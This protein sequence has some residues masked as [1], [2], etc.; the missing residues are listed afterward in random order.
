[1][2]FIFKALHTLLIEEFIVFFSSV[3]FFTYFLLISLEKRNFFYK[4][5]LLFIPILF[6]FISYSALPD[7]ISSLGQDSIFE[8]NADFKE[9]FFYVKTLFIYL[10]DPEIF[11]RNRFWLVLISSLVSSLFIIYLLNLLKKTKHIKIRNYLKH[12]N[13]L[14]L[15]FVLLF[16]VKVTNIIYVNYKSGNELEKIYVKLQNTFDRESKNLTIKENHSRDLDVVIYIG[17]SNSA[18]HWSLYGYPFATTPWLESQKNDKKFILFKNMYSRYTHTTPSL[19]DTLSI[20][21]EEKNNCS[22]QDY[23]NYK[24][25]PVVEILKNTNISSYLFSMQGKLGGHNFANKVVLN[26]NYKFYSADKSRLYLGNRSSSKIKDREF[27]L[28]SYCK[29]K[30]IFNKNFSNLILL[31]SYAGHFGFNGYRY[32]VPND[33]NFNYPTYLN[34]KNFLGN[35]HKNYNIVKEYDTSMRYVDQ[36]LE[37]V[38]SCS[39]YNSEKKNKPLV[40][41]YFSDHGESP[42][43]LRGHDSS[44][45][46]YEML[47]VPFFIYFNDIAYQKFEKEFKFLNSLKNKNLTLK[48]LNE[49]IFY[50]FDLQIESKDQKNGKKVYAEKDNFLNLEIDFLGLRKKLIGKPSTIKTLWNRDDKNSLSDLNLAFEEPNFNFQDTSLTLWQLNNFLIANNLSN[51]KKIIKLVCQ[52]R[53]NSFILQYK[54][55]LSNG[56]FETDANFIND[57]TINSSHEMNLNTNLNFTDFLQSNYKKTTIWMDSKNIG[58]EESCKFALNWLRSYSKQFESILIELP[59]SSIHKQSKLNWLNCIKE[60]K[61][62]SNVEVAYYL[63]NEIINNCSSQAKKNQELSLKKCKDYFLNV[64]NFLKNLGLNSITFDFERGKDAILKNESFQSLKWH[65]WH[66]STLND[67]KELISRNN[68][69]IILI[70]NDR[71][72][73]NLN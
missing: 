17:E 44:R 30:D 37:E 25:I 12:I 50:L 31:H 51:K 29:N 48:V 57:K 68:I 72:L 9:A 18:L 32:H 5:I 34:K 36:T 27:F 46:N 40:F 15:F 35:D 21:K 14:L 69:G 55:S 26:T 8:V 13:Y 67:F 42:S 3:F 54:N 41:V 73:N 59:T 1:M 23:D 64:L 60:I 20:C 33:I 28:K 52:H 43:S 71:N 6:I 45:L 19:I 39:F 61:E 24:I 10:F 66:V 7:Y 2:N 56:C 49:I 62:L 70:K 11:Y 4:Y 38:I 53:A 65:V 63:D 47:H 58:N 22:P 16:F